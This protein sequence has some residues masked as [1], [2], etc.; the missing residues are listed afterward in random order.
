M[1]KLYL[2]GPMRGYKNQ[3]REAFETACAKLRDMQHEVFNPV[4]LEDRLR[5]VW[6]KKP[7]LRELMGMDCKYICEEAEGVVCLPGWP[8]SNGA[9]AEVHLAWAIGIPVYEYE[10]F[11][12]NRIREV[13]GVPNG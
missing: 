3:N 1:M 12:T 7:I 9:L 10:M 8:G 13:K 6:S 11:S 4:E 5:S 2:A